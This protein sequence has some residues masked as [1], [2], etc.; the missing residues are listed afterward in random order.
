[1]T[2]AGRAGPIRKVALVAA[3]WTLFNRPSIQIAVLKAYLDRHLAEV[4]VTALNLFVDIAEK[5]GFETYHAL[6]QR[7]WLAECVYAALLYP[8]RSA[9]IKAWFERQARTTPGL[10]DKAFERLVEDVAGAT[11][12]VLNQVDWKAFDLMGFS[13]SLCQ[14]TATL[15]FIEK[16]KKINQD[17]VVVVGGSTFSGPRARDYLDA[18]ESIDFIVSGEGELPLQGLIQ[19]L[20]SGRGGEAIADIPG[21]VGRSRPAA[22]KNAFAQLPSLE[23]LPV[24]DFADYFERLN[25]FAPERRFFPSLP[26]EASRGC[27]W[28]RTSSGDGTRGCAFC[29][30]NLQWQGYRKKAPL[31]VAGEID[32]LTTRHQTLSIV[33]TDNVMPAAREGDLFDRLGGLCKDLRLFGEIRADTPFTALQRMQRSG[34][35][36]V[37]VGIESLSNCLLRKMNKGTTVIQNLEIMKHCETLGLVN[38][39]NLI[40][41]FPGSSENDVEETMRT[42]DFALAYQPLKTVTFWLGLESPVWRSYRNYKIKSVYNHPGYRVLFPEETAADLT[43]VI[44][45]YR[46][47]VSA[48]RRLWRRVEKKVRSWHRDY[49]ALRAEPFE[50][51]I[52]GYRDGGTFLIVKQR[53]PG[54]AAVTHRLTGLSREIYLYCHT[55]RSIRRILNKFPG[56]TEDKLMPFLRMMVDKRLMFGQDRRFL[57]LASPVKAHAAL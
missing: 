45:S 35:H 7:T 31:Q 49:T 25:R 18:F 2:W 55:N 23:T 28:Q 53:R 16:T 19:G 24:P 3:P 10:K 14:L 22:P 27:W 43:F 1:M 46:G 5:T 39:S 20:N 36:E 47:D 12:D 34:L 51:P 6:S 32:T 8:E 13:V 26:V 38:R 17:A 40:V 33:F 29:N 11:D 54:N 56:L 41:G 42:L 30:L 44:Q 9:Q 57:S 50:G 52:L 48:Q 21:V 37:Q 15:Y 4:P